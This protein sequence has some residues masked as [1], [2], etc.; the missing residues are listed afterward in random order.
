MFWFIW[1]GRKQVQRAVRSGTFHCPACGSTEACTFYEVLSRTM[2]Y[3]VIP[4]GRGTVVGHRARCQRCGGQFS[5]SAEGGL[6]VPPAAA[7][8]TWDCGHCG[9]TNPASSATCLRCGARTGG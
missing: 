2:L 1:W 7:G 4:L 3:S 6:V 5:T 9:N 8:Q